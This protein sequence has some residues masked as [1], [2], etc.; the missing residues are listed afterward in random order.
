MRFKPWRGALLAACAFFIRCGLNGPDG[1]S[2]KVVPL[3]AALCYFTPDSASLACIEQ[4]LAGAATAGTGKRVAAAAAVP[5]AAVRVMTVAYEQET[6]DVGALA[7]EYRDRFW[8]GRG[9]EYE[10]WTNQRDYFAGH[11][12]QM[13]LYEGPLEIAGDYASGEVPVVRGRTV[14]L[15]GFILNDRDSLYNSEGVATYYWGCEGF[16]DGWYYWD[17]TIGAW[18]KPHP[19]P[20][21]GGERRCFVGSTTDLQTYEGGNANAVDDADGPFWE[22]DSSF[23]ARF[24]V[25][26]GSF[27]NAGDVGV[28]D[29][30]T[31]TAVAGEDEHTLTLAELPADVVIPTKLKIAG[32]PDGDYLHHDAVEDADCGVYRDDVNDIVADGDPHNNLPPFYGVYFIKR[33]ARIY[34]RAT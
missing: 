7:P 25:G 3:P 9:W 15:V 16:E 27:D 12:S 23:A 19:T 30:T 10:N 6:E 20:A 13:L 11:P 8:E 22:V 17:D 2:R 32:A 1:G 29:T 34:F 18:I 21:S 28:T 31:S 33:T 5:L 24:P 4:G 14:M 26:V